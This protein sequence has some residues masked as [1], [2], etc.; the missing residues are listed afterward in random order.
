M[1]L[2][3]ILLSL[4][5]LVLLV[6]C[7][8]MSGGPVAVNQVHMDTHVFT[9]PSI[10]INKGESITL[11][12]DSGLSHIVTNGSWVN[13]QPVPNQE[14]GAPTVSTGQIPAG[15]SVTVGPFDTAGTFQLYCTIHVNMNL[16]VIVQ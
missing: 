16:T 1:K 7:G 9:V 14:A 12:N 13:G 15:G 4:L 5:A 11:V 6:G 2:R 8:S 10:T 3:Y